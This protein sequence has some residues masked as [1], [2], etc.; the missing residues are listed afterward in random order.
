MVVQLTYLRV[1]FVD[2][3]CYTLPIKTQHLRMLTS[4]NF[5]ISTQHPTMKKVIPSFDVTCKNSIGI[6]RFP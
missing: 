4:G 1:G 6:L 5:L 2:Q 3:M